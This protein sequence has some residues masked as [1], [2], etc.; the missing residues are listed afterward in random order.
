MNIG[1]IG[2]GN[3]SKAYLTNAQRFSSVKVTAVA[4]IFPA[5]AQ[6]RAE[7]F[8]VPAV[9]VD[10]LL[11]DPSIEAVV[12][13]T[14]PAAH[15][16]VGLQILEAG[17]HAYLEKP[18]GTDIES[19]HRLLDTAKTRGLRVGCAPDTFLGAGQQTARDVIDRGS[20]GTPLS[21]TAFMLSNGP[22]GW[23]PSP[24]FFYQEGGGP[25]LDMCPYYITTLVNLLGPIKS[26]IASATKGFTQRTCGHENVKGQTLPV[27]IN[28]HYSGVLE[29][30]SGAIIAAVFSFDVQA[31]KHSHIEIYGSEG[32]LCV[33]DP[34]G[35][36]GDVLVR[37]KTS[38]SDWEKQD[39]THAYTDNSRV[40]GLVDLMDGIKT[41]RPGRCDGTLAMHVLEVMLAFNTSQTEQRRIEIQSHPARPEALPRD[42]QFA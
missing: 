39:F 31:H 5:A 9:S 32:S 14:I 26:V 19:A 24:A 16:P 22:E 6:A 36:A 30:H 41:G 37:S 13:L 3:I 21:G 18:L 2:C 1:I 40:L 17:K 29:F 10:D 34:N 38:G 35:F 42:F 7:E 23:H 25:L 4:D 20:I 33:P 28:T 11:A 12:N 15:V 8:Q 27:E